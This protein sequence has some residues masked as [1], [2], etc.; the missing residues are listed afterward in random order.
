MVVG[1]VELGNVL[2]LRRTPQPWELHDALCRALVEGAEQS[3]VALSGA[4]LTS[5]GK[6]GIVSPTSPT[7][8]QSATRDLT[9]ALVAELSRQRGVAILVDG[10]E[11][12]ASPVAQDTLRDLVEA[13][14][15]VSLLAVLS[16]ALVTGPDAYMVLEDLG[17]RQVALRPVL[18]DPDGGQPAMLGRQF[19]HEILQRR[20]GVSD[21]PS[22][23]EEVADGA[24]VWSGGVPRMFLQL[25]RDAHTAA[26][27]ANRGQPTLDD[28]ATAV[29]DHR[30]SL[31][32][33]LR[34]GDLDVIRAHRG[35]TGIEIPVD[36]RTRL[37]AH[38]LLLEYE[39]PG[40]P[41]P[42]VQPHPLL[43]VGE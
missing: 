11:R 9:L 8:E 35:T 21:L 37:L 12:A 6:A 38:G 33:L 30:S 24:A 10:L 23:L 34:D 17:L 1:K 16:P 43:G 14:R 39:T 28:L 19:L 3:G 26:T 32:R 15:D 40:M 36:R 7:R 18:V 20:L 13:A 27:L 42:I 5:L 25:L 41:D 29:R 31:R 4:I 22:L 2:D